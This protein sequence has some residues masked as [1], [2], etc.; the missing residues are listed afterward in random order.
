MEQM[1]EQDTKSVIELASALH[2]NWQANYRRDNPQATHRM[3]TF[4]D[5]KWVDG[6][7]GENTVDLL[8]TEYNK[9]PS[10][11][12]KE[13]L[14]AARVAMKLVFDRLGRGSSEANNPGALIYDTQWIE[15]AADEVHRKWS[16]RNSWDEKAKIAYKD[17][18]Q[19]E[20]DK[21]IL[22]IHLAI[23]ILQK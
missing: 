14:M 23:Q 17:L 15:K 8:N 3:K 10:Y 12:Q 16:E 13:N 20:K 7:D 18:P 5:G 19:V 4:K 9:L 1:P 6:S 21:D 22:H 11:W 2:S